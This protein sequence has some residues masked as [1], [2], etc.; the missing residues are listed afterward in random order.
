MVSQAKIRSNRQNAQRSTGPKTQKGKAVVSQNAL[1]HGLSA[2]H[3]VVITEDQADFDLHR[4]S[5]LELQR[6]TLIRNLEP[7]I[8]HSQHNL[9]PGFTGGSPPKSPA[10]PE[11]NPIPRPHKKESRILPILPPNQ[12][13]SAQN[14][15]NHKT[16]ETITNPATPNNYKQKP[17]HPTQKK[18]TQTNPI[19]A[20]DE[21]RHTTSHIRNPN[22]IPK[23][24]N[25]QNPGIMHLVLIFVFSSSNRRS[26]SCRQRRIV[27]VS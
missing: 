17:P 20:R 24:T 14:K 18:Q 5:L 19:P 21:I 2:R 13:P 10:N 1:K 4:D 6:L 9:A 15:P 12:P 26:K 8:P 3:D 27:E 16:Q 25:T 22:P 7:P 23:W 11:N